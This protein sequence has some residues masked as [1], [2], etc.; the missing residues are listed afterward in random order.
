VL[1]VGTVG[2]IV[3]G[4]IDC[5]LL[6]CAMMSGMCVEVGV[7]EG[8][9][10]VIGEEEAALVLGEVEIEAVVDVIGTVVAETE[11]VI[12]EDVEIGAEDGAVVVTTEEVEGF[13]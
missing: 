3:S 5:T 12:G 13:S 9:D 10:V 11:V 8:A 6:S 4:F 1:G 7:E 2:G